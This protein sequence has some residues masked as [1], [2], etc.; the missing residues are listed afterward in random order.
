MIFKVTTTFKLVH[1]IDSSDVK[2][3]FRGKYK[4]TRLSFNEKEAMFTFQIEEDTD[5]DWKRVD[6]LEN[7]I[8]EFV[9][10]YGK[11]AEYETDVIIIK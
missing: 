1:G 11:D 5:R 7:E 2:K 9:R 4:K 3:Y 8:R 6:K 10:K